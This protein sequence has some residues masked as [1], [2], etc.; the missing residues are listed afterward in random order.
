MTDPSLHAEHQRPGSAGITVIE[1]A[2][3]RVG[4]IT[5]RRT[6]P[7][8]GRRMIGAWCFID[9]MGPADVG[10]E[11]LGVAPHPHIGLQTVTWLLAGEVLHRDS[12]GSEQVIVPGQLNLMTAGRG[13][14]HSEEGTGYRGEIHGVQ[15]WVAQPDRTRNGQPAFEHHAE[16][17]QVDLNS[18]SATVLIG[19]F[20]G[21]ESPA[22][23][24]SDHVGVDLDLRSGTLTIPVRPEHEHGLVVL[25]GS[26]HVDGTDVE[27]GRM[28]T[29]DLGRD[30]LTIATNE[31]TRV[32]LVGGVP[33]DEE[34]R[35]WWNYV[36]RTREEIVIAHREWTEDSGRFGR[37]KSQLPRIL[38]NPPP[39]NTQ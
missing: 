30:E 20:A 28:A 6:L 33:F 18:G 10:E 1:S 29:F 22:R 8:R 17:P 38:V 32:L 12:L 19:E 37:V 31:P 26:V 13:V 9:H 3:S 4:E 35:M 5:V 25:S 36:A 16:L 14:S 27:P 39:W 21:V 11:G 23:R 15:L 34:V 7:R 24:D 2:L